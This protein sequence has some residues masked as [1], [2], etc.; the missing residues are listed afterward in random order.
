MQIVVRDTHCIIC[1]QLGTLAGF[2]Y[3]QH[4]STTIRRIKI[5]DAEGK[6]LVF[7]TN[8]LNTS[9]LS[10]PGS[11]KIGESILRQEGVLEPFMRIKSWLDMKAEK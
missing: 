5:K 6:T 11:W 3:Q 8:H 9:H 10:M 2:Y 1:D 7:L 4:F